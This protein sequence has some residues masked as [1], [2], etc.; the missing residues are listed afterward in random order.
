MT[1]SRR[2]KHAPL[3]FSPPPPL[4]L[5]LPLFVPLSSRVYNR[6]KK[7]KST[8]TPR[9]VSGTARGRMIS[10]VGL[11]AAVVGSSADPSRNILI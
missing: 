7:L 1:G 2:F 4:F 11:D 8:G 9:L 5:S 3:S 10:P 6:D